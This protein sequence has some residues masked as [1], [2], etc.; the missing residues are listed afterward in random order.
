[1]SFWGLEVQPE[2]STAA[3]RKITQISGMFFQMNASSFRIKSS[4]PVLVTDLL[5]D[6]TTGKIFKWL[7]ESGIRNP[8][9]NSQSYSYQRLL[10][11][12]EM[13]FCSGCN[14]PALGCAF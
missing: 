13:L 14:L 12:I 1:M 10:R 9:R 8:N 3:T 5:R 2:T 7:L 11:I 6:M 4:F